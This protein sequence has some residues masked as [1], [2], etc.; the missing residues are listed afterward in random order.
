M[1]DRI[2]E[3]LECYTPKRLII[4]DAV[5]SGVI[6]PLVIYND[7]LSILFTK[8][9]NKVKDHKGEISFPGGVKEAKDKDI[10]ETAIRETVEEL[11]ISRDH[12]EI[13]GELD[14]YLTV[15]NYLITP[16]VGVIDREVSF[17][18][19]NKEEIDSIIVLPLSL[20]LENDCHREELLSD[21]HKVHI[22]EVKE[23]IIWGATASILYNFISIIKR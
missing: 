8:R 14:D 23:H 9:S 1:L 3:R 2:K 12:I 16:F 11:G 4:R 6:L 5:P 21:D 10:K 18:N 22:Y 7:L 20:F 13:I 17:T 19:Y 15:T